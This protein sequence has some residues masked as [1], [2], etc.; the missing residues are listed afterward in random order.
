VHDDDEDAR[1]LSPRLRAE[2]VARVT[3]RQESTAARAS[4]TNWHS[5][6]TR[7]SFCRHQLELLLE[8]VLLPASSLTG[9]PLTTAPENTRMITGWPNVTDIVPEVIAG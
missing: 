4:E 6:Y 5:I 8:D 1:S 2:A 3:L 9:R 7:L